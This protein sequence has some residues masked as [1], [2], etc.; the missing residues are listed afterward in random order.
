MVGAAIRRLLVLFV[1]LGVGIT[2]GSLL[3]GLLFGAAPQRSVSLGFA[4][5][6]SVLLIMGFFVGSHGPVRLLRRDE[7][8]LIGAR[9]AEPDERVETINLSALF[10]TIGFVLLV[11][12]VALD[13][14]YSFA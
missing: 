13:P 9:L 10:I 11:V 8:S 5:V 4:V 3:L 2:F 7:G 12:G 6:G 14:R 1:L